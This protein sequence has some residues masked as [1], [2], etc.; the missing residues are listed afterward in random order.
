[1]LG[2][3]VRGFG[4]G[5]QGLRRRVRG[6]GLETTT[7]TRFWAW[8]S[9]FLA[10]GSGFGAEGSRFRVENHEPYR[11][12]GL[13]VEVSGLGFEVLGPNLRTLAFGEA[14]DSRGFEDWAPIFEPWSDFRSRRAQTDPGRF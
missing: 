7:P 9:R 5:V 12:F 10:W 6:F 13:G 14:W 1:M 4:L 11:G 3:G 2:F 8:G